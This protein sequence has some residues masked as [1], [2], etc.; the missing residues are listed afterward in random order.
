MTEYP[1]Y[2]AGSSPEQPPQRGPA[3]PR[4]RSIQMA[5][6]LIWVAV[7]LTVLSTILS[8]VNLD[9]AARVAVEQDTTGTMTEDTA[10]SGVIL[11]SIAFLVIGVG[12]Y[13]LL[14]IFLGKGKN[15]ARL[16]YTGL[17][18]L[19]LLLGILGLFGEQSAVALLLNLLQIAVTV[20]TL[21][22]L[23]QK[24]SSAWLTGRTAG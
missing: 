16:V 21:Y 23:W 19:F 1:Q 22:F 14:A 15:W 11:F 10:R 2:P 13:A 4:P 20:A 6:N 24:E 12:L 17:A 3:G 9:E 7:G 5:V 8:F 18:A